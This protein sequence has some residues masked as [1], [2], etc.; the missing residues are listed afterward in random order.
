MNKIWLSLILIS[1]IYGIATGRLEAISECILSLP[2]EGLKLVCTLVFTACFWSGIMM[3]M[4]DSGLID[5]VSKALNPFLNFIMP[6]LKSETAKKFISMNIAAN[7][8]GLGFAA[9]PAGLKAMKELKKIS[10]ED[11]ETAS[12]EMVTFLV[13]NTAG[14]TL[15]PTTVMAIR[16][17]YGAKNPADFIV[18]AIIGTLF[19]CVVGLTFDFIFRKMRKKG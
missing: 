10:N 17:S 1:S 13:L 7:M 2:M 4:F 16:Q 6:N 3:I 19:S 14:V 8:F 12:D 18:L 5:Q 9:T 15:I 11:E